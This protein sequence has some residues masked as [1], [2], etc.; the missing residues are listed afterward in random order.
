MTKSTAIYRKK[1]SL[2][3]RWL[4]S[5]HFLKGNCLDFGSGRGK[6]AEFY[7]MTKY[8]LFWQPQLP[9]RFKFD[10]ITCTYVLNVVNE[11]EQKNILQTISSL[12]K[13]N[14]TAYIT[15]R[16]DIPINGKQGRNCRQRYVI[17]SK[18]MCIRNISSYAIYK[19]QK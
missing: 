7:S 15:V 4:A 10:T 17:L 1:P 14:G 16:R 8:D 18:L 5:K 11:N 19:L 13:K 12:L 9:T 3:A 6:D 2:P